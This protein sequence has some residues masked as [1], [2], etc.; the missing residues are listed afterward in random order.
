METV[1]QNAVNVKG[2]LLVSF[3]AGLG[4]YVPVVSI[5]PKGQ[6]TNQSA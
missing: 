2:T 5:T 3:L 6:N 1:V 4:L